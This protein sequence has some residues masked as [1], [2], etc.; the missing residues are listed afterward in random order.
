MLKNIPPSFSPELLKIM[1]EMG[2]LD[3]L[4]IGDG[5]FP[6]ASHARNL[7]RCDGLGIPALLDDILQFFPLDDINPCC[8]TLM[9]VSRKGYG[10]PPVWEEYRRIIEKREGRT[11]C[12]E[13]LPRYDFY[14]R[15]KQA[16][17]VVTTSESALFGNIIIKKG[18]VRLDQ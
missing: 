2:H 9:E 17:A 4:V 8:V 10:T 1:M 14:D 18:V 11:D 5:N 16:Y 15:A 3:D 6:G 13:W 12:I 7:I